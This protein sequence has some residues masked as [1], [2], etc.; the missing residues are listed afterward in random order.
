MLLPHPQQSRDQNI[1]KKRFKVAEKDGEMF[2]FL[3]SDFF[4]FHEEKKSVFLRQHGGDDG[5]NTPQ[6]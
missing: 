2:V 6:M 5:K 3:F 1:R 4:C